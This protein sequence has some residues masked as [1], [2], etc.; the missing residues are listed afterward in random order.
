MNNNLFCK[1]VDEIIKKTY[2]KNGNNAVADTIFL[3]RGDWVLSKSRD[4][5]QS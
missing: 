4:F 5:G 1:L 2:G 3:N